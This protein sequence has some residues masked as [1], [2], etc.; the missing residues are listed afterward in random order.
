MN[1]SIKTPVYIVKPAKDLREN[2]T[3]SGKKLWS[4]LK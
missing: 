2:M 3:G 1:Q 4:F